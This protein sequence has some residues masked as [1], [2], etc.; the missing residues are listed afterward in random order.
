MNI[1]YFGQSENSNICRQLQCNKC[2][3]QSSFYF[4][5]EIFKKKTTPRYYHNQT[6]YDNLKKVTYIFNDKMFKNMTYPCHK[7]HTLH[8]RK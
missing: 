6:V 8:N 4:I 7:K 5:Y 1:V 3:F 2:S